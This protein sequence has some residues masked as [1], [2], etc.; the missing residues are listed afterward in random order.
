MT[1]DEKV[2]FFCRGAKDALLT[3][4]EMENF[5]VN[6]TSHRNLRE[7]CRS[8]VVEFEPLL[9]LLAAITRSKCGT[10]GYLELGKDFMTV[11]KNQEPGVAYRHAGDSETHVRNL[12][13]FLSKP[14]FQLV[15]EAR[16]LKGPIGAALGGTEDAP[17]V[18]FGGHAW[19][20]ELD[21]KRLIE[22]LA[23]HSCK[24]IP[25]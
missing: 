16:K 17:I 19:P 2:D 11:W 22:D 6:E 4:E 21:R 13:C 20:E 8:F 1:F 25:A 15:K 23:R 14:L 9:D 7:L 12:V 10:D 24:M 18:F 5:P 3:I